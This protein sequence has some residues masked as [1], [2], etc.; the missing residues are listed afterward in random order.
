MSG[1]RPIPPL[2]RTWMRWHAGN[3]TTRADWFVF[4]RCCAYIIA[5]AWIA[6]YLVPA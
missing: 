1:P 6:G 5:A 3:D 2:T 4:A